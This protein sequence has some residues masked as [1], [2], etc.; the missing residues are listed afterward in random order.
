MEAIN[1][2]ICIKYDR[3][4]ADFKALKK[5]SSHS[6][7]SSNKL[8]QAFPHVIYTTVTTEKKNCYVGLR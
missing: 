8:V 6:K 2:A 5:F 1:N 7:M 3:N 4:F